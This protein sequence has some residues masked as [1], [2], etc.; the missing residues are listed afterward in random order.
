M[1]LRR[2]AI[3]VMSS[4]IALSGFGCAGYKVHQVKVMAPENYASSASDG[5]LTVAADPLDSEAKARAVFNTDLNRAGFLAV[6]LILRNDSDEPYRIDKRAIFLVDKR[7]IRLLPTTSETM[8]QAAGTSI[9]KWY[10]ISGILGGLSA[11]RAK[12]KMRDDFINKELT[13][14][15]IPAG[16]ALYGF[17]YFQ[18][19]VGASGARGYK[20]LIANSPG[21]KPLEVLIR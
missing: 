7:G 13:E 18:H 11:S 16:V 6:N 2:A 14:E 20:I 9:A 4:A 5:F 10:F 17:L 21:G 8:I 19:Q 3:L 15:T 12:K 1:L